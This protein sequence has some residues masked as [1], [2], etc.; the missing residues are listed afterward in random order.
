MKAFSVILKVLGWFFLICL[1]IGGPRVI[2]R[3]G[4]HWAAFLAAGMYGVF[5]WLLFWGARKLKD[6]SCKK[7]EVSE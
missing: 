2:I 7:K 1:I 3:E 5:A 4:F 6:K